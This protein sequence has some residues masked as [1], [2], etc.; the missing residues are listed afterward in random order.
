[1]CS[2]LWSLQNNERCECGEQQGAQ[3]LREELV[4]NCSEICK[5]FLASILIAGGGEHPIAR[6]RRAALRNYN[7]AVSIACSKVRSVL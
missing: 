5:T 2:E 1:M 3:M 6:A 7:E 4:A